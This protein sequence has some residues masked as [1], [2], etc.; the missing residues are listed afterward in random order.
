MLSVCHILSLIN[1]E[2]KNPLST[3]HIH[4]VHLLAFTQPPTSALFY[5]QV[6]KTVNIILFGLLSFVV[7]RG[8][9]KKQCE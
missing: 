6:V 3:T 4:L 2:Q 8:D 9:E 1:F 7:E 5:F